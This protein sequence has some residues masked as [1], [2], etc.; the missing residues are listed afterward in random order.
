M[1][2]EMEHTLYNSSIDGGQPD[3]HRVRGPMDSGITRLSTA[4]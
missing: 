3:F 2:I 1:G 4:R